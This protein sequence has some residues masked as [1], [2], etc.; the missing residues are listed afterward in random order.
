MMKLRSALLVL[1]AL[2]LAACNRVNSA[3]TQ[4]LADA[5]AANKTTPVNKPSIT[6][7]GQA[8]NPVGAAVLE[9][10]KRI[11]AYMKIHNEA[12]G[13]VPNLRRTDDPVE[14]SREVLEK[15]AA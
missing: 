2:T 9:F 5:T 12:E 10:Q 14:I 4:A 1:V 11:E 8:V 3:E 6:A 15:I 7:D 13:K